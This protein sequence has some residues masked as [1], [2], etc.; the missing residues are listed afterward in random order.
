M[1]TLFQDLRFAIRMLAKSPGFSTVAV[2][3]LALGI[4]ANTAIFSIVDAV[5]LKPL[6]FAE[7]AQLITIWENDKADG[8]SNTGYAT[9]L[10]FQKF[11]H[12]FERMAVSSTWVP[13]LEGDGQAERIAGRRVSKDFFAT[14]R[15][16]PL[17]GRDFTSEEDRP[18]T[19]QS[20]I[21]GYSL[22]QGHF[23]GDR[24]ILGQKIQ[25][26][27]R[28]YT[29]V[30][31]LPANFDPVFDS[32]GDNAAI[33]SPLG[34]DSSLPY[35]CRDCRHLQA[36]GRLQ[37]GVSLKQAL[38]DLQTISQDL[39]RA[40]PKEYSQPGIILIPLQ[41]KAVGKSRTTLYALFGAVLMV[42]LIACANVTGLLLSRTTE[43]RREIAVRT[44]L[45]AT[46]GRLIRQLLA[47]GMVLCTLGGGVAVG[48]GYLATRVLPVVCATKIPLIERV[49][50]DCHV[51]VFTLGLSVFSGLFFG[52]IPALHL[53]Q[54]SLNE[55]LT[56]SGRAS[57]GI[58]RRNLRS[59]LVV[60]NVAI[61]LVLLLS[62]GLLLRSLGELL[63]VDPG[64]DS[65]NVLTAN[66]DVAGASYKKDP[67]FLAFYQRVL[68]GVRALPGV[69]SVGMTSQLPLGGNMDGY[70]VH[71]EGKLSP[72]PQ[73]D[74]SADGYS[75]SPD[76]L[77]SM[78]I[79]V[80]RGRA[81]SESDR[82]ETQP[83]VLVNQTLAKRMWPDE[84]PVGKRVKVGGM[85]SP[86]RVIVGVVGDVL[87]AGLD[88]SQSNQIYLPETQSTDSGVVLV[89]RTSGPPAE[90]A[91][92]LRR[93]VADIDKNQPLSKIAPMDE[94]LIGSLAQRTFTLGLLGGFAGL[95]LLLA[96]VGIYGLISY[97]VSL[98]GQEIGVRM[99]LGALP[100][101]ILKMVLREG[102]KLAAIG[103]TLGV[104]IGL[105]AARALSGLLFRV[106]PSDPLALVGGASLLMLTAALA[107]YLPARRAAHA[108]PMM[109][110]RHE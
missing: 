36:I 57:A 65:R 48:L 27:G 49:S 83:V 60:A 7:P 42:L 6:G 107:S 9:F 72:N 108:D 96:A 24:G 29:V 21:L 109:A 100:L 47:E 69:Q 17:Y 20:V 33:W 80:L 82:A 73:N 56:E 62:A 102:M 95:A 87:H 66:L 1:D 16:K 26:S 59:V 90:L 78:R 110:L 64:F 14:L 23:G 85:D 54:V 99:A 50:L 86:W 8:Q 40:Y 45:G 10:D 12:T 46:R 103:L 106:R 76:Y 30:G 2:L 67:Q 101:D 25:L 79:P 38:A 58:G 68:E 41:E 52:I 71:I 63:R 22:W 39:F 51:L 15:V 35:A 77:R 32:N 43:R 5:L 97:L 105:S 88:A 61:A 93:V 44:A 13:I 3:T 98:R 31:I 104:A 19:N 18:G 4:G 34:Y 84:D 92:G 94:V 75:I 70:G 11:N 89:V 81:F 53:G 91:G 55:A 74:P 37:P 28:P